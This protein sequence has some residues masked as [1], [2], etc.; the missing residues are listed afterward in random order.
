M[1]FGLQFCFDVRFVA[2]VLCVR[3]AGPGVDAERIPLVVIV[4]VRR[5][6]GTSGLERASRLDCR[7]SLSYA[8]SR[9]TDVFSA[10]HASGRAVRSSCTGCFTR[11]RDM[12]AEFLAETCGSSV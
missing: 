6:R 3:S 1:T 5:P 4:G 9:T 8:H 7:R 11:L 10:A 2:S 12:A